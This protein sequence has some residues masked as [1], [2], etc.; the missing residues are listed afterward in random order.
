MGEVVEEVRRDREKKI[1]PH[2]ASHII[3]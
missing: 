2:P 3:I 1:L